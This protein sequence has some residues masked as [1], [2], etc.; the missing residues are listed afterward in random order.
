MYLRS[1][2]KHGNDVSI[3][4]PIGNDKD[5]NSITLEDRLPDDSEDLSDIVDL[6]IRVKLLYDRLRDTLG[7]RE[8]EI[9]E[10]RYGLKSGKEVTQREIGETMGISRSYV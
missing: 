4:D 7:A 5:G 1:T 6:R 3:Y 9:I 2:K 8:R 10:M